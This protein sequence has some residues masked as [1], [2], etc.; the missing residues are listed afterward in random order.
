MVRSWKYMK[1]KIGEWDVHERIWK[2][3]TYSWESRRT[4]IYAGQC[5]YPEKTLEDL[6]HTSEEMLITPLADLEDMYNQKV[7]IKAELSAACWSVE[8]MP[9]IN[10]ENLLI[11]AEK[12]IDSRHLSKYVSNH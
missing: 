3:E 12:Y 1:R 7:K 8:I 4:C 5:T 2:P 9:P 10:T 6:N 11:K